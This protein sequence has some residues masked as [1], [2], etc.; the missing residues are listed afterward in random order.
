VRLRGLG[1]G[2]T[3]GEEIETYPVIEL[4]MG[5]RRSRDLPV[6]GRSRLAM[7]QD[8]EFDGINLRSW[9]IRVGSNGGIRV[10]YVFS[11]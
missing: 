9:Y 3:A 10:K 5:G 6:E 4:I 11:L 1:S 2:R 8:H 7:P